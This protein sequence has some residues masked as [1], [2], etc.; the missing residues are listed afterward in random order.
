M[1]KKLF[2]FKKCIPLPLH[3]ANLVKNS[4]A[5]RKTVL[6]RTAQTFPEQR[7]EPL[8]P[9]QSILYRQYVISINSLILYIISGV[10]IIPN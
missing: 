5:G 9:Y 3:L 2:I 1:L 6:K 10:E 8:K 7:L 4:R